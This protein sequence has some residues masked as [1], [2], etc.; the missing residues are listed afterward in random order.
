MAEKIRGNRILSG[1]YAEVW[2]D[3]DKVFE[4]S[5][6]EAK[7][8]INREDIQL[9]VD[10]DSKLLG[11]KGEFTLGVKKVFSRWEKYAEAYK[12]GI[13][14]R[15]TIVAK[16]KDPNARG[17][18]MERYSIGNC[19]FNELPLV[20]YE[21]GA[22]VEEEVSGGFTPSDMQALDLIK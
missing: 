4:C 18:Q 17:G 20:N 11:L 9:G 15:P 12:Q 5:K 16:L 13:D 6:I 7:M 3:G 14:L 19:W 21:I 22:I 10:V 1:T 2:I 8:V